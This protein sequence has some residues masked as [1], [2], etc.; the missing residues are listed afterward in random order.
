MCKGCAE[1]AGVSARSAL[2]GS[3]RVRVPEAKA[4]HSRSTASGGAEPRHLNPHLAF[5]VTELLHP[6]ATGKDLLYLA[7]Y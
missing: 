6:K 2:L 1:R 5:Q 4:P 3:G 7:M